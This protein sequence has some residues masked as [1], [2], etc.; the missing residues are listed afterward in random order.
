MAAPNLR[1]KAAKG[2]CTLCRTAPMDEL[3]ETRRIL[4]MV[5]AVGMDVNWGEDMNIC[6]DC[7]GVIADL[8][9]RVPGDSAAHW[10]SRAHELE[11]EVDELRGKLEAQQER[12]KKIVEGRKAEKDQR[13]A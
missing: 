8:I 4:P 9:G 1:L 2:S 13:A 12:F 6:Q 3:Q 5:V 7:A 10:E 11:D